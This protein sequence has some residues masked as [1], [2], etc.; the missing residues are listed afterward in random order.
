MYYDLITY[1]IFDSLNYAL[2]NRINQLN[3]FINRDYII[4]KYI[5]KTGKINSHIG[6]YLQ[7][8]LYE[9]EQIIKDNPIIS[10]VKKEECQILKRHW[11][12]KQ[13]SPQALHS[14]HLEIQLKEL[15]PNMNLKQMQ[16]QIKPYSLQSKRKK[17]ML[18]KNMGKVFIKPS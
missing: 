10:E 18:Y 6:F 4:L 11:N 13:K 3:D 8:F 17:E 12:K 2:Y 1:E 15:F 5:D 16:E 9:R 14:I 7:Q